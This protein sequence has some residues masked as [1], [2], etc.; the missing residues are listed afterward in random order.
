[1][2]PSRRSIAEDKV[3][4]ERRLCYVGITRA[5]Q[6]LYSQTAPAATCIPAPTRTIPPGFWMIFPRMLDI[7]AAPAPVRRAKEPK[8]AVVFKPQ[9]EFKP[10]VKADS[11]S[12]AVGMEVEHTKFGR[13]DSFDFRRGNAEGGLH[14]VPGWGTQDVPLLCSAE[15][16]GV[17]NANP[18]KH[19]KPRRRPRF[20]A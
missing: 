5:K 12:F 11:A 18:Q 15:N 14:Q 4:E 9:I 10:Q 17:N 13:G 8:Q 3:D 7:L 6:L 20:A 1:M 19:A 16:R 2:F